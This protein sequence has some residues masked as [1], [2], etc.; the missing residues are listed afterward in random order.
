MRENNFSDSRVRGNVCGI[1]CVVIGIQN[2][3]S[4]LLLRSIEIDFDQEFIFRSI[5][6]LK[7]REKNFNKIKRRKQKE[8]K[9]RRHK[10][11]DSAGKRIAAA[12][13]IYIYIYIHIGFCVVESL[14]E[15]ERGDCMLMCL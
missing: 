15:D 6:F 8:K 14:Y 9:I 2:V 5:R 1:L 7:S 3:S 13:L 4:K 11:K 10:W 12:L